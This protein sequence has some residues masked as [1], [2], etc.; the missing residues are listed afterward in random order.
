MVYEE[1][2]SYSFFA[3]PLWKNAGPVLFQGENL[4]GFYLFC[5]FFI[6]FSFVYLLGQL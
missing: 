5:H 1:F 6:Q 4:W 2:V 3:V